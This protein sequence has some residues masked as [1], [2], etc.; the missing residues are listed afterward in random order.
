VY[1][2]PP[3]GDSDDGTPTATDN[4]VLVPVSQA[5]DGAGLHASPPRQWLN[6]RYAAI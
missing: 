6:T 2:S 4:G 1:G 3:K 5:G